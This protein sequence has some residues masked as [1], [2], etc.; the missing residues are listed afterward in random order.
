[1]NL[2][3]PTPRYD[4]DPLHPMRNVILALLL[5]AIFSAPNTNWDAYVH[6]HVHVQRR[7]NV[8][9]SCSEAVISVQKNSVFPMNNGGVERCTNSSQGSRSPAANWSRVTLTGNAYSEAE[10]KARTRRARVLCHTCPSGDHLPHFPTRKKSFA[11]WRV[12]YWAHEYVRLYGQYIT[13]VNRR[14]R[15]VHRV[16][17][18]SAEFVPPFTCLHD[19]IANR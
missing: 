14:S 18:S 5:E 4:R 6:L 9:S 8:E 3:Y 17:V 7:F 13:C 12:S 16:R 19:G 1:M 11:Y 15:P 2:V 10:L